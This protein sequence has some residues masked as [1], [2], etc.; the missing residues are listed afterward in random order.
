M[1]IPQE[2]TLR[3]LSLSTWGKTHGSAEMSFIIS[4]EEPPP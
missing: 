1:K 2:I 3:W 4:A